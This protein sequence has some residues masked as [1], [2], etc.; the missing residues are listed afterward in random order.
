MAIV[1]SFAWEDSE[2][3]HRLVE[4]LRAEGLDVRRDLL[5]SG[6]PSSG[7]LA[8]VAAAQTLIAIFSASDS[9]VR[10]AAI[11]VAERSEIP[12]AAVVI[13]GGTVPEGLPLALRL[14]VAPGDV[15]KASFATAL[16]SVATMH[17]EWNEYV[18]A[19]AAP[20]PRQ[21]TAAAVVEAPAD[22]IQ[23]RSGSPMRL[24]GDLVRGRRRRDR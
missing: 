10:D 12:I 17:D 4:M 16:N 3:A 19:E 21:P 2:Y 18:E 13:D 5:S 1:I 23:V 14:D 7:Y 6:D 22:P 8:T 11:R 20:A 9:D 15:P 24:I